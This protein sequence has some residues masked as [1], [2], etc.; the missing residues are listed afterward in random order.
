MF[1]E[2]PALATWIW[3]YNAMK[4]ITSDWLQSLSCCSFY[5]PPWNNIASLMIIIILLKIIVINLKSWI[6]LGK[7]KQGRFIYLFITFHTQGHWM[8]V[9]WLKEHGL[10]RQS[11]EIKK[12]KHWLKC[13]NRVVVNGNRSQKL[14]IKCN[15]MNKTV[16]SIRELKL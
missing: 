15:K 4:T 6:Q 2:M 9:T 14:I 11:T 12:K 3:P 8:C 5:L 7:A 10:Q 13:K 16:T 1:F